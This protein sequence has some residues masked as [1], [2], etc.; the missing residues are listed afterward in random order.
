M[1]ARKGFTLIETC[2]SLGLSILILN[3]VL[4]V[5]SLLARFPD[6]STLRQNFIG[7]IQL[8]QILSL[9]RDFKLDGDGLC[10]DYQAEQTCF[11]EANGMLIQSPGTQAYLI[12]IQDSE[13]T[14]IDKLISLSYTL[15]E[16]EYQITLIEVIN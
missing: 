3:L 10:M 4:T 6:T 5:F 15:D 1:R 8:R 11:H 2:I 9:G 13:F 7:T 12:G 14:L 16:T